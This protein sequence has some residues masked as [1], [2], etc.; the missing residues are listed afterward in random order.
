MSTQIAWEKSPTAV[1]I[2]HAKAQGAHAKEQAWFAERSA[3]PFISIANKGRSYRK[4]G[5]RPAGVRSHSLVGQGKE[6]A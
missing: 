4:R 1:G 2:A 3:W 5:W 6:V